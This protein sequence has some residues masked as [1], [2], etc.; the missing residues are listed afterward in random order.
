M[1]A[2][3]S[4]WVS[5]FCLRGNGSWHHLVLARGASGKPTAVIDLSGVDVVCTEPQIAI[6]DACIRE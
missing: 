1:G 5:V 6:L 4:A 3:D 2:F